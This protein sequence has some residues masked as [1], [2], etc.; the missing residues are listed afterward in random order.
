MDMGQNNHMEIK[1]AKGVLNVNKVR[2]LTLD[3]GIQM[4]LSLYIFAY[5]FIFLKCSLLFSFSNHNHLG[6]RAFTV[7]MRAVCPARVLNC[8]TSIKY[9]EQYNLRSC[10][11][12]IISL[13]LIGQDLH[14]MIMFPYSV[15]PLGPVMS[16][17][18]VRMTALQSSS[19]LFFFLFKTNVECF[20]QYSAR[21]VFRAVTGD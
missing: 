8:V 16:S 20:V 12:V 9:T 7:H 11:F 18:E 21:S 10:H 15:S 19:S 1:L 5:T 13:L 3:K 4:T 14:I 2:K 6:L 17:N